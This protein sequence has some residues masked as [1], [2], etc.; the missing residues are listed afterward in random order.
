MRNA[1]KKSGPAGLMAGLAVALAACGSPSAAGVTHLPPETTTTL[2]PT[3]TTTPQQAVIAGYVAAATAFENASLSMNP[4]DPALAETSVDPALSQNRA[5]LIVE[6][7]TGV[8]VR[9]YENLGHPVV[10]SY[11]AT[12]AVVHSC[13]P[14]PGLIS[15]GADGKPLPTI[16]GQATSDDVTAVMVPGP[17]GTWM[18]QSG[19]QK[20]VPSCPD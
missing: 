18:F 14:A 12:R 19:Q 3:T 8:T 4:G 16:L 9:G 17:S 10:V 5:L 11:S 6:R 20:V 15:Y 7:G 1:W 13:E 2:A